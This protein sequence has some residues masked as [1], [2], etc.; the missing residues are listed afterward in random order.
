MGEREIVFTRHAV[1]RM[2]QYHMPKELVK[3]EIRQSI[4]EPIKKDY[5]TARYKPEKGL[6]HF[7][8]GRNLYTI[9]KTYDEERKA[10]IA[11]VITVHRNSFFDE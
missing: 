4:Q 11:L 2:A 9:S 7:I 3:R 10:V 1:S 6:Y 8:N 5:T